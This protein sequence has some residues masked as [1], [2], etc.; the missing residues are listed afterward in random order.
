MLAPVKDLW[1]HLQTLTAPGLPGTTCLPF[2]PAAWSS[3]EGPAPFSI[4]SCEEKPSC[5]LWVLP[6]EL[7][8]T[9]LHLSLKHVPPA[10]GT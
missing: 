4:S 1:S 10:H 6:E 3:E 9:I 2:T 5:S 7:K 8:I